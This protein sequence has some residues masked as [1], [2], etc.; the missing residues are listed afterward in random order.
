MKQTL[1]QRAEALFNN[2]FAD[3]G[4]NKYNQAAW[5]KAMEYLGDKHI[6]AINIGRKETK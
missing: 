3:D 4:T 2:P 5:V 6:L 1:Q